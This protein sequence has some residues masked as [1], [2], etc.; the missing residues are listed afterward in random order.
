[1]DVDVSIGLSMRGTDDAVSQ[2]RMK[3]Q[4]LRFL[5]TTRFKTA[6]STVVEPD[7]D[8]PTETVRSIVDFVEHK[9]AY[10]VEVRSDSVSDAEYLRVLDTA[11]TRFTS[12]TES[13]GSDE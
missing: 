8:N 13:R 9:L 2:G 7:P 5:E 10:P 12:E 11:I 3:K 1:M 4:L 6:R